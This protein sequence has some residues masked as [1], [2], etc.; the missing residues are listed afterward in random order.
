MNPRRRRVRRNRIA[1]A[2][3]AVAVLVGIWFTGLWQPRVSVEPATL[4]EASAV[5]NAVMID[6]QTPGTAVTVVIHNQGLARVQITSATF[7]TA[8]D[9]DDRVRVLATGANVEGRFYYDHGRLPD[10][11]PGGK[12]ASV[13]VLLTGPCDWRSSWADQYV[14]VVTVTVEAPWGGSQRLSSPVRWADQP[15]FCQH[16]SAPRPGTDA[17][18]ATLEV[19]E[20]VPADRDA[21]VAQ[22]RDAFGAAY[23]AG[24]PIEQRLGALD[25]PTGVADAYDQAHKSIYGPT[26]DGAT[27][28]VTDVRF[29]GNGAA[30]V[31]Y[32]LKGPNLDR[33]ERGQAVLVDGVWKVDRQT[34]CGDLGGAGATC[35]P[36][37]LR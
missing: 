2:S 35:S 29:I 8:P 22:I 4:V 17:N 6:S 20:A 5:S 34:V 1:L 19:P 32:L 13:N 7:T 21:A 33:F 23:N 12:R 31:D 9:A 27:V 14:G 37:P 16:Q 26:V 11:V 30:Q 10:D 28:A 25:D 24:T 18:G 15:R 3:V 36:P